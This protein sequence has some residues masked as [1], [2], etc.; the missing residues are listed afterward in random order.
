MK[1]LSLAESELDAYK[2]DIQ[3]LVEESLA[4]KKMA[5]LEFLNVIEPQCLEEYKRFFILKDRDLTVALLTASPIYLNGLIVGYF[6]NDILKRKKARS[7]SCDL[8]IIEAMRTLFQEGILEVRLGMC[9]LAEIHPDERNARELS[10]IFSKWKLGYNFK[11]LYNFKMKLMPTSTRPLYLASDKPQLRKML[12]NVFKLHNSESLF[13]E[14][15]K[16][17]WFEYKEN[18][19]LKP[20]AKKDFINIKTQASSLVWRIKWTLSFFTFYVSLHAAKVFSDFGEE[21]YELS[22]YIPG[23][24][25]LSGI[26]LGPMFHN[27]AYHIIGDQLSFL[28]FAGVLEFAFG[29]FFMLMIKMVGLWFSN[30]VTHLFLAVTLKHISPDWWNQ[31][32]VEKDWGTSNAVFALVGASLFVLKKNS[33]LYLPFLFHALFICFQRESFLAIHHIMGLFLGYM[34]AGLFF[35]FSRPKDLESKVGNA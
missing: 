22:A 12:Y 1:V 35:I 26:F 34:T 10:K 21:L 25:T 11:N 2:N 29:A 14:V 30:P 5:P 18:L 8:L 24:V 3:E 23:E 19:E 16:R 28:I 9:P 13:K 33:W 17:L 32:L 27:H 6:F 4:Q 7:A 15:S 31:V 20:V